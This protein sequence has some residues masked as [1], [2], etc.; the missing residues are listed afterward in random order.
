MFKSKYIF[1]T[2]HTRATRYLKSFLSVVILLCLVYL[3]LGYFFIQHATKEKNR[4]LERFFGVTPDL[5]V[6]L[7]GDQGRIPYGIGLAKKYQQSNIFITGVYGK[8]NLKILMDPLTIDGKIDT[9]LIEIDYYANNTFE[10]ALS[11]LRYLRE[12]KG[13]KNVLVVSHDYHIP[14]IKSIFNSVMTK[15][16]KYSLYYI[17]VESD[18]SETRDLKVLYKEVY[19]Y[20]RT[21]IFL[22]VWDTH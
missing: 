12:K 1:E 6:I 11:T 4:S 13:F 9:N 10:N 21:F 22:T 8:N 18:F 15:D 2:R 19:K 14:R 20:L 17:G 16:D 3:S 5:I 7:T